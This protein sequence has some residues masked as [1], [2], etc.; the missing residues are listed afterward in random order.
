MWT[1]M[2]AQNQRA[3]PIVAAS[4]W[5]DQPALNLCA[6]ETRESKLFRQDHPERSQQQIVLRGQTTQRHETAEAGPQLGWPR[7]VAHRDHKRK[8]RLSD[9]AAI[10]RLRS[11]TETEA[12]DLKWLHRRLRRAR[13]GALSRISVVECSAELV[14]EYE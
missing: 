7:S 12:C 6:V 2:N 14:V 8:R 1:T 3:L 5:T 10:Y 9:V 4:W 13:L 11:V